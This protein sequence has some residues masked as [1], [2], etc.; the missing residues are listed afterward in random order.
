MFKDIQY[1]RT[2]QKVYTRFKGKC[3]VIGIIVYD[4]TRAETFQELDR[5]IAEFRSTPDTKDAP[6]AIIG[7][8]MDL[9]D[10]RNVSIEEGKK[11]AESISVPFFE[12][13]AK[14]GGEEIQNIYTDLVR[15]YLED[16]RELKKT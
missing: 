11:Y 2:V 16:T 1:F 4:I 14:L 9:E 7:N 6:I 13:S 5:W 12:C 3:A 15:K 10:I 8:K